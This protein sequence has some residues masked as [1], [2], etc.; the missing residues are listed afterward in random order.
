MSQTIPESQITTTT[1]ALHLAIDLGG[2][3][4]KLAFGSGHK[5]RHKTIPAGDIQR[6]D[7]EVC[8]AKRHFGL[9]A[10]APAFSCYE[11]GRDGFWV[12]RE[13][14]RLG[15]ENLVVDSASI[16]QSRRHRQVKTDRIDARK[17]LAQLGRHLSGETKVWSAVQIPSRTNEDDR[18]L[19]REIERLKKEKVQLSNGVRSMLAA[20]GVSLQLRTKGFAEDLQQVRLRDGHALGPNIRAA[21]LRRHARWTLVM[22]QLSGLEKSRREQLKQA[23]APES[24]KKA[25]QMMQ[26]KGIGIN[27]AWVLVMELFGWRHFANRREVGAVA[28]LCPTPW[29]SDGTKREQGISKAGNHR[30]R[31]MIVEV[32][33]LWLRNQP[34]SALSQW[35][36]RKF[37][38]GGSRTRRV[39]I[40]ALA[41]KL[42]IALWHYV[43]HGVVPDGAI[44]A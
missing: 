2:S 35:F 36:K 22:E 15:I 26:L 8:Q 38:S 9:P 25:G 32:S 13:L 43:E 3:S 34:E 19:H 39:G 5:I 23:D 31:A 16:E 17:L 14:A 21:L 12:H 28:G 33:W 6:L 42:L 27:T 11:A 30:V 41:R 1:G 37:G 7:E 24:V 18:M 44:E 10:D 20:Q 4:W 29:I 40:V